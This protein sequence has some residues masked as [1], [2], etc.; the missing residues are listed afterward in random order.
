MLGLTNESSRYILQNCALT[1]G[2]GRL[3]E[4]EDRILSNMSCEALGAARIDEAWNE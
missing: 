4:T 2:P 1:K 3:G